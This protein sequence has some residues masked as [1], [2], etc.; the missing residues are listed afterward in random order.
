MNMMNRP[1]TSTRYTVT[2]GECFVAGGYPH[3][4]TWTSEWGT[5]LDVHLTR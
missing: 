5:V 2:D 4:H 3:P 1:T